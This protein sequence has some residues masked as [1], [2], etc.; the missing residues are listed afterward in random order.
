MTDTDSHYFRFRRVFTLALIFSFLTTF[1]I[2]AAMAADVYYLGAASSGDSGS[3]QTTYTL[4]KRITDLFNFAS[5]GKYDPLRSGAI[6]GRFLAEF[7]M[8]NVS[9]NKS[10]SFYGHEG[11]DYRTE[12][13]LNIYERL[14]K[15]YMLEGD[16][17]LRKTDNRRIDP[18]QDLRLEQLSVRIG[19][20]KNELQ[21]GD[22]YA[23]FS[24]FTLGTSLE[25]FLAKATPADIAEIQGV[26]A[27]SQR[28]DVA[29]E[30]YQRNAFGGKAD[31]FLFATSS[32]FS[33]FRV[34]V[35]ALTVQDDSSTAPETAS[36][37]DEENTVVSIDG[38][39]RFS[40]WVSCLF[41]VARSQ[42][43]ADDEA[44]TKDRAH[45]SAFRI[46]PAL[47]YNDR[48]SFTYLYYYV[49]PDFYTSLGSAS[50]DKE[51]HQ[52]SLDLRINEKISLSLVENLY[53]DHL[54]GSTLTQRTVYDEKYITMNLRPFEERRSFTV[55]P[56]VNH[57][58]KKSDDPTNSTEADT[59]TTGISMNDRI[60]DTA[61]NAFYEY[62]AYDDKAT[63]TNSDYFNRF[64]FGMS[65]DWNVFN[66]RLYLALNYS[67]DL[68]NT[69][70]DPDKDVNT[71]LSFNG[72]YDL[73]NPLV[74]RFGYNLSESNNSSPN[75]DYTNNKSYCELDFILNKKRAAHIIVRGEYNR[76]DHENGEQDYNEMLLVSRF[77]SNF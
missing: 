38:E 40:K 44:A 13:S 30:R 18:R 76:Y 60:W 45:G 28:A 71:G 12:L 42:Y 23:D 37:V 75:S 50:R 51:Q 15:D 22:F 31:F 59:T 66:R 34:G 61:V 46:M 48:A 41:E 21:F 36:V 26:A 73:F 16:F 6:S 14:Y 53:W 10:K 43:V 47:R 58:R 5:F 39:I 69:K 8:Q 57:L 68:R 63:P 74:C 49:Q 64:G 35:Q 2:Q 55:R 11:T 32:L 33:L 72:S 65:R 70:R 29:S 27:R 67:T 9:G 1:T 52:F 3:N 62:R 20:D 19:N 24:P 56:Y 17:F 7:S 54:Q 4:H 25:G 77:V